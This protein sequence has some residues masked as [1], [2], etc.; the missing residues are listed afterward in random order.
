MH[1][2][3]PVKKVKYYS[4]NKKYQIYITHKAINSF[5]LVVVS[6]AVVPISHEDFFN[7]IL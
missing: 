6:K 3:K 5:I 2:E 7:E 4:R 1:W